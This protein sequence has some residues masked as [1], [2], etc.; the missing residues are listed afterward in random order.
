MNKRSN[1]VIGILVAVFA[2]GGASEAKASIL[3]FGSRG[4]EVTEL[5][6][7]LIEKG[8]DIP[9][10]SSGQAQSGYFGE[11]TRRAVSQYQASQGLTMTGSIDSSLSS[12]RTPLLGA[13]TSPD[14]SSP[15]FSYGDVRHWGR[16]TIS[17]TQATTTVCALQSPAATS[18]LM[19]GG[20]NLSVSSTTASVVTIAK[21]AT[22]YATTT[23]IA[24]STPIANALLNLPAATTTTIALNLPLAITDR[25]FGPS[26]WFVVGMADGTAEATAGTFSPTGICQATFLEY[27]N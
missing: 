13:A 25:I 18:T 23:A 22:Q 9:A 14:I 6:A 11:Q 1:I 2:I 4:G 5:Q 19:S 24:T 12:V 10:I 20:I 21:A 26:T 3:S 15:Y 8:F 17:L 27:N 7:T 16:K